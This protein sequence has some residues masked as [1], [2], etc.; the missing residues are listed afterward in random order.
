ML[1]RIYGV[2]GTFGLDPVELHPVELVADLIGVVGTTTG[3]RV[4]DYPCSRH[5]HGAP[6]VALMTL[7]VYPE[8]LCL[9]QALS[10]KR[11]E[12]ALWGATHS[13]PATRPRSRCLA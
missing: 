9:R 6:S 1:R 2:L 10:R 4:V 13:R 11:A 5:L 3:G 12:P 7:L 8:S